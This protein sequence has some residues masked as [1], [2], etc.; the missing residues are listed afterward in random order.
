MD[1]MDMVKAS[2]IRSLIAGGTREDGRDFY[3]FRN[4][5][6]MQLKD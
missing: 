1:A 2:H 6:I 5:K 4:I 3:A